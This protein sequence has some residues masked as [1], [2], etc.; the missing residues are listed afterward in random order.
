[1]RKDLVVEEA[2]EYGLLRRRW[3]CH[4]MLEE[5]AAE[6]GDRDLAGVD[7]GREVPELVVRLVHDADA[8]LVLRKRE[9]GKK[10]ETR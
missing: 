4:A 5:D 3:I 8:E 1:L 6:L 2:D 10:E 9:C 7:S